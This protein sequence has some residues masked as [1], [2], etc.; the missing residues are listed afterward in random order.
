MYIGRLPLHQGAI[1]VLNHTPVFW[2]VSCPHKLPPVNSI[3][4]FFFHADLSQVPT[5]DSIVQTASP[6]FGA[7]RGNV[8]A[9]SSISV[10]LELVD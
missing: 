5:A 3:G 2:E 10:A 6:E 4:M 8:N 9:A 1:D 7:I